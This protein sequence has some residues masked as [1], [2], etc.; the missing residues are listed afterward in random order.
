MLQVTTSGWNVGVQQQQQVCITLSAILFFFLHSFS[1]H[2]FVSQKKIKRRRTRRQHCFLVPERRYGPE[3]SA[4]QWRKLLYIF[5]SKVAICV[6][7]D[8]FDL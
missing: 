2:L 1:V 6:D 8:E 4:N 5:G 3:D 7:D